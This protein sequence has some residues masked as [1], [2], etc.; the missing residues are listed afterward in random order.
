LTS[1]DLSTKFAK[2]VEKWPFDHLVIDNFLPLEMAR[3]LADEM[4]DYESSVWVEYANAIEDKRTCNYWHSFPA[5]TYKFMSFMASPQIVNSLGDAFGIDDLECDIGL[6]GGGWHM[7]RR[8]G[9]LNIHQDYSIHPKLKKQRRLNFILYLSPNWQD[10]W[11]GG[12]QLWS[13]SEEKNAPKQCETTVKCVFNRAIIFRTDQQSW[14]G[15]PS[16]LICPAGVFRK[17]LAIYYVSPPDEGV[18]QRERALFFPT[19]EQSSDKGVLKLIQ[20]RQQ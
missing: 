5:H 10:Q 13:H 1:I 12:L 4:P 18:N 6:H 3:A 14:H 8:G 9:K 15:L 17:S 20:E 19:A 2:A 16:P 11:G 7:H